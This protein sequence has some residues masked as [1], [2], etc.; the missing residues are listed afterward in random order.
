MSFDGEKRGRV[1]KR[2]RKK[3]LVQWHYLRQTLWGFLLEKLK[4]I[5]FQYFVA[6]ERSVSCRRT[7]DEQC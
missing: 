5:D 1:V 6:E 7:N 4:S 2:E 3:G